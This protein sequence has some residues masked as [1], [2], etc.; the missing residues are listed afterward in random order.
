MRRRGRNVGWW[1]IFGLL[2]LLV[3]LGLVGEGKPDLT[4][5]REDLC[6]QGAVLRQARLLERA[7][8]LYVEAAAEGD[9][10][11]PE[12][13]EASPP[14]RETEVGLARAERLVLIGAASSSAKRFKAATGAYVKALSVYPFNGA[15]RLGLAE[16]LGNPE[17][18]A[19]L[20]PA[21]YCV[22]G[23]ELI[24]AG[25]LGQAQATIRAGLKAG[26]ASGGA[27]R[28][29]PQDASPLVCRKKL[30]VLSARSATAVAALNAAT[31]SAREGKVAK[32][33]ER[34]AA[35]LVANADLTE[36]RTELEGAID[37]ESHFDAIGSWLE[38]VTATLKDALKWLLPLAVGLL[39]LLVLVWIIVREGSARIIWMRR[40]FEWIGK[41]SVFFHDAAV[42]EISIEPFEGS[43]SSKEQGK[44]LTN[45]LS[46][47]MAQESRRGRSF[48][49]DRLNKGSTEDIKFTTVVSEALGQ[50][51]ETKLLGEL[52]K[53]ISRL[54]R[55]RSI[56]LTGRLISAG[57]QGV[58]LM[59]AVQ[60][61]GRKINDEVI[62]WEQTYDP[63]PEG[64]DAVRYLR[65]AP[66]A[67]VW[68]RQKL[69]AAYMLP[70]EAEPVKWLP[71]A[72][73]QSGIAWQVRRDFE[74][75]EALYVL[76]LEKEP[77]LL[78]AAHNLATIEMHCKEFAA[79]EARL[80]NLR[81]R[82]AQLRKERAET[83]GGD[84]VEKAKLWPVLG[85]ASLYSLILSIAYQVDGRVMPNPRLGEAVKMSEQLVRKLAGLLE[86][87]RHEFLS[88]ENIQEL[89]AAELPSIVVRA[90]LLVRQFPAK[91][92]RAIS[93][94]LVTQPLIAIGRKELV[95]RLVE[96][97]PWQLI[98]YVKSREVVSR[99]TH[100]NLACYYTNLGTLAHRDS[101]R[102]RCFDLALNELRIS[103]V[104]G[105]LGQ[106]ADLDPALTPL[107]QAKGEAFAEALKAHEIKKQGGDDAATDK[108]G[109]A[110]DKEGKAKQ[111][112]VRLARLFQGW[113]GS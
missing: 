54:F 13:G 44:E 5:P 19:S 106:W 22:L 24:K 96:L 76:A 75:A 33:R 69:A 62:L 53:V 101:Q 40:L 91:R 26:S 50:V 88:P 105:E 4:E 103:L 90:S 25:V 10:C 23:S 9:A 82:L 16:V 78:P 74:R 107:K 110:T 1:V 83:A 48:P 63:R 86:G 18:A 29:A 79:A 55:R 60:G 81:M 72:L 21:G 51:S 27:L 67:K 43:D 37:E 80:R 85:T 99:R 77:D 7:Q 47:A 35:A 70:Q 73:F 111:V 28:H 41:G 64:K 30:K 11:G 3:V 97:E 108:E 84:E 102:E 61:N 58:G 12:Q 89:E 113:F 31:R 87:P 8:A 56:V 100:Y 66:A 65:L 46:A 49:F 112:R 94:A 109:T 36:A 42:P 20:T 57:D 39:L 6:P 93:E 68:S 34:Y 52:F 45:L 92:A 95:R 15:A 17:T 2:A 104:G 38:G 14:L 71:D 59:L 32:A 98:D